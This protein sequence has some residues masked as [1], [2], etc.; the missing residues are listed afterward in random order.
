MGSSPAAGDQLVDEELLTFLRALYG[1]APAGSFVE[2]RI[3]RAR[4]MTQRFVPVTR[5]EAV[6][7]IVHERATATDVYVGVLPRR[8]KAGTRDDLASSA[9]VLWVDCDGSAAVRALERFEPGPALV[10]RSGSGSN[11]HAYWLLDEP[12]SLPETEC[13]NRRLALALGADLASADAARILRPPG[14]QNHKHQPPAP[15][16]L[17]V[18]EPALQPL[19]V[20]LDVLP[21]AHDPWFAGAR[22][23]RTADDDPLRRLDPAVYVERL[24]G[25]VV[26]PGR[27]VRCPLHDDE[28]PSLHVYPDPRRGWYCFGCRRGGSVYDLAAL[29]WKRPARG[30]GFR[31]LRRDLTRLLG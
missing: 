22:G 31:A 7:A 25:Q 1:R 12:L 9:D 14:S 21:E 3:R 11:C 30:A 17:A 23:E 24:T 13:A 27:K 29:M 28:D 8:R 10:V 20:I 15:V 19:G 18:C 16:R 4:G 5:L 6:E 26:G 2:L